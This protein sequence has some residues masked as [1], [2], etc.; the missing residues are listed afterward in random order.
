MTPLALGRSTTP[1]P[2]TPNSNG[3]PGGSLLFAGLIA[4]CSSSHSSPVPDQASSSETITS[5]KSAY[6]LG[7]EGNIARCWEE[8]RQADRETFY[9][10]VGTGLVGSLVL[11]GIYHIG[12]RIV[13]R[14]K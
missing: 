14:K 1:I 11:Y 8:K 7:Q 5:P 12:R 10:G 2:G 3:V 6:T 4:G 9:A 13:R